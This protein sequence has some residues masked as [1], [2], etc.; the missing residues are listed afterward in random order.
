MIYK[1]TALNNNYEFTGDIHQVLSDY[2]RVTA[3]NHNVIHCMTNKG[4]CFHEHDSDSFLYL[5]DR[6]YGVYRNH[7]SSVKRSEP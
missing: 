2:N 5:R 4:S 1:K 6:I 3:G 7:V